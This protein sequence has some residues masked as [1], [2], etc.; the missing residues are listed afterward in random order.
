MEHP[1][2]KRINEERQKKADLE[3][4]SFLEKEL[5]EETEEKVSKR[6]AAQ[7]RFQELDQAAKLERGIERVE[8][9]E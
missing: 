8:R 9:G 5:E 1:D 2:Q 4:A 7:K 6:K 3:R